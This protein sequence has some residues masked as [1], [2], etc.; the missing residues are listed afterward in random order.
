MTELASVA[1]PE[2]EAET[3][4]VLSAR[5]VLG[6]FTREVVELAE[7]QERDP[8]SGSARPDAP[9]PLRA[10]EPLE[11]LPEGEA[12]E[13]APERGNRLLHVPRVL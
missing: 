6:A 9:C 5:K 13:L 12:L 2:G 3:R 7:G 10:D 1:A 11:G 8:S 4:A